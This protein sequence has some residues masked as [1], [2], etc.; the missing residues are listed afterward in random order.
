MLAK[1][2]AEK[3]WMIEKLLALIFSIKVSRHSRFK[4]SF[5]LKLM[6]IGH[7]IDLK[8]QMI[9][10]VSSLTKFSSVSGTTLHL[11]IRR[12]KIL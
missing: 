1:Y 2:F 10:C 7:D 8:S 3:T 9:P 4:N 11:E 12:L 6:V 5:I